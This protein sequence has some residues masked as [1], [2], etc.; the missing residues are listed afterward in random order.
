MAGLLCKAS[1]SEAGKSRS[2][3]LQVVQGSRSPK[4]ALDILAGPDIFVENT[5]LHLG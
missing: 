3:W 5:N 2:G 4:P 1:S